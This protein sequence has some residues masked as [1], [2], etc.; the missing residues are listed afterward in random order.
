MTG[1]PAQCHAVV[2]GG[3]KGIGKAIAKK[4]L[5][6][7]VRVTWTG[8]DLDKEFPAGAEYEAVGQNGFRVQGLGSQIID[9]LLQFSLNLT[10][11]RIFKNVSSSL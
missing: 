1:E 10:G 3:A 2:T 6:N 5:R 4:L 7:G 8:G 11:N 9:V